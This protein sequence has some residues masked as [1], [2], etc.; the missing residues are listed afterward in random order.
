MSN[1]VFV[2]LDCGTI[3]PV[4]VRT[5]SDKDVALYLN[6]YE[7]MALVQEQG[8]IRFITWVKNLPKEHTGR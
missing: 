4:L 1:K 7:N 5:M 8:N 3:V 2:Q 6:T